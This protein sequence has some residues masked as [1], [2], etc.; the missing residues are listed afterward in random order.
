MRKIME[1]LRNDEKVW[2]Y[3][4]DKDTWKEFTAMAAY[5]GFRFGELPTEMWNYGHIVAVHNS[6]E[7]GH[8]PLYI[9][10]MSFASTAACGVHKIDFK[11]YIDGFDDY[12]CKD[13]HFKF[14]M[15]F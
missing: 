8:I 7:L 2:V 5:E 12:E 11:R 1:M 14:R 15:Y 4:N 13:S 9:W 10:C 3:I 6:G